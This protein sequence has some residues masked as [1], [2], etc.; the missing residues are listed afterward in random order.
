[1]CNKARRRIKRYFLLI[2]REKREKSYTLVNKELNY[3]ENLILTAA[4]KGENSARLKRS[5]R[6]MDITNIALTKLKEQGFNFFIQPTEKKFKTIYNI[7]I[8]GWD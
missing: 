6:N 4:N 1:M 3:I 2:K 7:K 5:S 8:S